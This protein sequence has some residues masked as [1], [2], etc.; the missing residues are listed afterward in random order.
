MTL[1]QQ[2]QQDRYGDFFRTMKETLDSLGQEFVLEPDGDIGHA[3]NI[4]AN[5]LAVGLVLVD[6]YVDPIKLAETLEV[7]N[8]H[9]DDLDTYIDATF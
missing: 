3:R 1:L 2:L 4:V 6:E 9:H 7:A 5:A 8:E